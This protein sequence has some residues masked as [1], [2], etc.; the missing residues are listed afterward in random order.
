MTM[1]MSDSVVSILPQ[2]QA[3][4][5]SPAA[6][7]GEHPNV[8]RVEQFPSSETSEVFK[9][10]L[11]TFE[12]VV[13]K[14]FKKEQEY[15][16]ESRALQSLSEN[17]FVIQPSGCFQWGSWYGIAMENA[18]GGDCFDALNEQFLV[19][20]HKLVAQ[21]GSTGRETI[22]KY[23]QKMVAQFFD[24]V[25]RAIGSLHQ[26]NI[27]HSDFKW[28]NFVVHGD[29]TIRLIDFAYSRPIWDHFGRKIVH[30]EAQG[31]PLYIS[32]HMVEEDGHG[33]YTWSYH[34]D[35]CDVWSAGIML[36]MLLFGCGPFPTF[37]MKVHAFVE[38][39]Q[40]D[41]ML[42]AHIMFD[43]YQSDPLYILVSSGN[44]EAF[45]E[46]FVLAKKGNLNVWPSDVPVMLRRFLEECLSGRF[47]DTLT[48]ERWWSEVR[49][50]F[51]V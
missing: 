25:V 42:T 9:V 21:T 34:A 14:F 43:F 10:T 1:I 15:L 33:G 35:I 2:E 39:C 4:D 11:K 16:T 37:E 28:E 46:Q 20:S 19:L 13:L 23:I 45:W 44:T 12:R 18:E 48:M 31:T 41:T 47:K 49:N 50:D 30:T 40:P 26:R 27:S 7:L 6:F 36:F 8:L 22:R 51:C 5:V 32:P 38:N 17:P 29:E 24:P 3:G